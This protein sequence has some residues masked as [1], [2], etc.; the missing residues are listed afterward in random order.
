[1]RG[2]RSQ[3]VVIRCYGLVL[4]DED[5]QKMVILSCFLPLCYWYQS[6]CNIRLF[7]F[8]WMKSHRWKLVIVGGFVINHKPIIELAIELGYT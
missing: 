4:P 6:V 2:H 5:S 1:M 7:W 8:S 3:L